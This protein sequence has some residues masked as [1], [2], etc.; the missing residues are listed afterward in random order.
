MTIP[1]SNQIASVGSHRLVFRSN[2]E[3]EQ[4]DIQDRKTP[5][6]LLPIFSVLYYGA[7]SSFFSLLKPYGIGFLVAAIL[8]FLFLHFKGF[9]TGFRLIAPTPAKPYTFGNTHMAFLG[10]M[11]LMSACI[12]FASKQGLVPNEV[13]IGFALL[14]FGYFLWDMYRFL[15]A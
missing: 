9:L 8:S 12:H 10:M 3:F 5:L 4:L 15:R 6:V 7:I 1:S 13:L 2:D 14:V 11:A